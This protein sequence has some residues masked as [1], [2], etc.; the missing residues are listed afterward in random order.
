MLIMESLKCA[1]PAVLIASSALAQEPTPTEAGAQSASPVHYG[2][3]RSRDVTPFGFLRLD[4]QPAHA[5]SVPPGPWATELDLGY[6]NTCT[7]PT[8]LRPFPSPPGAARHTLAPPAFH[9][10]R[11]LPP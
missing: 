8:N 2:L 11:P 6:Q 7:L 9:P 4:M 1:L 10:L 5:V 3:L